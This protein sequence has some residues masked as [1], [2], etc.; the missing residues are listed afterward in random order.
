[1]WTQFP[2]TTEETTSEIWIH[3]KCVTAE[4]DVQNQYFYIPTSK[5]F[6]EQTRTATHI[7]KF[8]AGPILELPLT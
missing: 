2:E 8:E 4:I 7:V 5:R 1:M 6:P 3:F